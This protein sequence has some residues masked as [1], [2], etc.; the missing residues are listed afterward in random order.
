MQPRRVAQFHRPATRARPRHH[1]R[2]GRH[3]FHSGIESRP[4]RRPSGTAHR[5]RVRC[6]SQAHFTASAREVRLEAGPADAAGRRRYPIIGPQRSARRRLGVPSNAGWTARS[7]VAER[8]VLPPA[9][10]T[11][12]RLG[13][14]VVPRVTRTERSGRG[15]PRTT[16][17]I[18]SR[19]VI[20]RRFVVVRHV[21]AATARGGTLEEVGAPIT[22][23]L[24]ET[25]EDLL[26]QH[27]RPKGP[28]RSLPSSVRD[29]ASR[30][31]RRVTEAEICR[32]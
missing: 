4:A 7:S 25:R 28:S 16:G 27:H 6:G 10:A 3:P 15:C 31:L 21:P 5:A 11:E 23:A 17:I 1:R 24:N 30:L 13:A 18:P 26:G 29:S 14:R 32:R 12:R 8:G 2:S 19:R 22:S 9:S 20:D